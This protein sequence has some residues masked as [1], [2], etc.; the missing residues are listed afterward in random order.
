MLGIDIVEIER[1]KAASQR[2]S[3]LTGVY[4]EAER[5]YYDAHGKHAETLAGMFCA[6]EAVAKALGTGFCGF[7][8][9]E[10]EILHTET[11]APT[12]RLTGRAKALFPHVGL[13]VSI[14]HCKEYATAVAMRKETGT[15]RKV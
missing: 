5:E 7:R 12:V 1:I 3:F 4:T 14:S 11:G 8:P 15:V 2:E 10:V 9:N 13:E 6:K